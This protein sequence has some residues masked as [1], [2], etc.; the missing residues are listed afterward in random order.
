MF[1]A[2]G[3]KR[4]VCAPVGNAE[5]GELSEEQDQQFSEKC[6]VVTF[7]LHLAQMPW[8]NGFPVKRKPS[9]NKKNTQAWHN[10]VS[11]RQVYTKFV[12]L[13]LF[14]TGSENVCESCVQLQTE[15]FVPRRIRRACVFP[16]AIGSIARLD[17]GR[18]AHMYI[19]ILRRCSFPLLDF[20]SLMSLPFS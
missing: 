18:F 5:D 4:R 14:I 19:M 7:L 12:R 3:T 6:W 11:L 2:F 10:V 17:V 16:V 13:D 1:G 8:S 9:L 20:H 15:T